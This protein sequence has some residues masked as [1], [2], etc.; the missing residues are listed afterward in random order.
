M[1]YIQNQESGIVFVVIILLLTIF[2]TLFP[3]KDDKPPKG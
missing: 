1:P 2:A 3:E